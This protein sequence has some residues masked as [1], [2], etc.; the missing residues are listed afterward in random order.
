MDA[1]KVTED[2][3][4]IFTKSYV[5][6]EDFKYNIDR[7][8]EIVKKTKFPFEIPIVIYTKNENIPDINKSV[9]IVDIS[10]TVG[11]LIK[12]LRKNM[13]ADRPELEFKIYSE[14]ETDGWFVDDLNM[15]EMWEEF[16]N[17]DGFL[18]LILDQCNS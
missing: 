8:K 1:I 10:M 6:A 2:D 18:Y 4:V 7:K 17:N 5:D 13:K 14:G 9:H 15:L 16:R 3:Y 11:E 12:Y